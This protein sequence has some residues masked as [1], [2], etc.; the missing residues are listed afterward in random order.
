MTLHVCTCAHMRACVCICS[1]EAQASSGLAL[2]EQLRSCHEGV[3]CW[4]PKLAKTITKSWPLILKAYP[5]K[6]R[7][8]GSSPNKHFQGQALRP[9]PSSSCSG[10]RKSSA[11][12]NRTSVRWRACRPR[13]LGQVFGQHAPKFASLGLAARA[14]PMFWAAQPT[15]TLAGCIPSRAS[16]PQL[17]HPRRIGLRLATAGRR[18]TWPLRVIEVMTAVIFRQAEPEV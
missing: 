12:S 7:M 17:D 8:Q 11:Q 2:A 9:W 6:K 15:M 14:A 18:D 10:F 5:Q 4:Q 13:L 16:M 3:L 1:E